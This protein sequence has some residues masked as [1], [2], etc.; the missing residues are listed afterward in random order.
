MKV[1]T[2]LI[3]LLS[4]A[5]CSGEG[6]VETPED[7]DTLSREYLFLELGMGWHDEGHVDAYFGPEE[8]RVAANEAQLPL[9]E[10]AARAEALR[11]VLQAQGPTA[12][13]PGFRA[14][15]PWPR[16]R[17]AAPRIRCWPRSPRRQ[18]SPG[19]RRRG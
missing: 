1:P 19:S 11:A 17:A 13:G 6:P 10:I 16:E 8:I 5:A 12:P 2:S 18:Q 15:Q 9:N 4:L 3:L 14:Q 7:M